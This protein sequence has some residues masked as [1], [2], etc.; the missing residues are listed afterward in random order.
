LVQDWG[1]YDLG[2]RFDSL[3]LKFDM[4]EECNSLIDN[5]VKMCYLCE[6]ITLIRCKNLV[7]AI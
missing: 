1:K 7:N 5:V 3:K 6:V 2:F 4:L